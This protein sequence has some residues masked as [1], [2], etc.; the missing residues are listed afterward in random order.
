MHDS[1]S[2]YLRDDERQSNIFVVIVCLLLESKEDNRNLFQNVSGVPSDCDNTDSY[3]WS[4]CRYHIIYCKSFL[5]LGG[6][7]RTLL[8]KYIDAGTLNEKLVN[9]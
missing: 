9:A 1:R 4:F 6:V 3:V 5:A 2:A 7:E 8:I